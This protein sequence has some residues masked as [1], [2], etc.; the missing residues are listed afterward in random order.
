MKVRANWLPKFSIH[1]RATL[2][3]FAP[4]NTVIVVG[5]NELQWPFCAISVSLS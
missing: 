5:I 1:L 2:A 4:E 3:E